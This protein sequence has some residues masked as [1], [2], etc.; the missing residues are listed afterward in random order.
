MTM[1][2][3]EQYLMLY[4][5]IGVGMIPIIAYNIIND[6]VKEL[7]VGIFVVY[8]MIFGMISIICINTGVDIW[9]DIHNRGRQ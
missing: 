1:N 9:N 2:I 7:D 5:C 6:G 8:A 4:F 3:L